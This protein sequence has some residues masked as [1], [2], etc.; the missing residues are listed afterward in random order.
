MALTSEFY[1][2]RASECAKEAEDSKLSNV[3]DRSR[4]AEA[5][6]LVMAEQ[7]AQREVERDS[8]LAEKAAKAEALAEDAC[9]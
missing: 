3:R 1:L 5:A 8:Q 9:V 4:R 7:S 2:A 6:W